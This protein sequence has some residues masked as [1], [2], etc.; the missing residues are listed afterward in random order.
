MEA[1][2]QEVADVRPFRDERLARSWLSAQ[3]A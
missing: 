2:L 3:T 1:L